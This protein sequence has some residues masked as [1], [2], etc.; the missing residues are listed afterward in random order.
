MIAVQRGQAPFVKPPGMAAESGG[1]LGARGAD[2]A[3]AGGMIGIIGP[4]RPGEALKFEDPSR[5]PAKRY[6]GLPPLMIP[7]SGRH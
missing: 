6:K 7:G 1:A 3:N 2:G 4:F 5:P